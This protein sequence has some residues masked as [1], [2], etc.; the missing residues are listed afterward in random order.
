MRLA[1]ITDRAAKLAGKYEVPEHLNT[2]SR[3]LSEVSEKVYD[4]VSMAGEAAKRGA[5]V[6]YRAALNNPKT[7]IAGA[8]LAAAL[9]G[10]ALW[11]VFGN[12]RKTPIQ[13]RRHGP[14]VRAGAERR[15]KARAAARPAA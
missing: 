5:T 13:R 14:R 6:A 10:G 8:V 15:R 9:I 2:A 12:W 4:R 1:Q 11:Y 3:K 7:S